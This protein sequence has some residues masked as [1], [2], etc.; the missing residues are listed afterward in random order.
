MIAFYADRG[1][2]WMAMGSG[3]IRPILAEGQTRAEAVRGYGTLFH[4]QLNQRGIDMKHERLECI[5]GGKGIESW[6]QPTCSC[7][8]V[9]SKH[10][11]HND[12][13]H[14]NATWQWKRHRERETK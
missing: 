12:A 3:P 11:A 1:E 9:G 5:R 6:V 10:Y 13:Q 14:T 8:W 2:C 7:G 4:E